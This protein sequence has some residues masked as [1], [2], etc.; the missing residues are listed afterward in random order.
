MVETLFLDV[1]GVL[2]SNGWGRQARQE[3]AAHFGLDYVQMQERHAMAFDTYELGKISLDEYLERVV[4]YQPRSF[5]AEQF[6]QR[7]L[8]GSQ[9]HSPSQELI[10]ELRHRYGLKV[11]LVSNE[12]REL[13]EHRLDV[14]GLRRLCDA[15]VF[16]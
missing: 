3:A 12:G 8:S 11:I 5:T 4:F 16:S 1:G 6:K 13:T 14:L 2:G 15:G 10:S 7:M 9:P